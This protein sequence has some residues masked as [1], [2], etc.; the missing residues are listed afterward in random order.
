MVTKLLQLSL[1]CTVPH[2]YFPRF[3]EER[4][5]Q[6]AVILDVGKGNGIL[7]IELIFH[8]NRSFCSLCRT[9]R[10]V[11]QTED[12]SNVEVKEVDFMSC[13]GELSGFDLC[14][15][16]G[17]FDTIS[18]NQENTEGK[19]CYVQALR[20]EQLLQMLSQGERTIGNTPGM[21]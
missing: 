2:L 4:M 3:G 21:L 18:L 19:A 15:D 17:A 1:F 7:L 10:N 8:R 9:S 20:W 5:D 11:L 12:L 6:V 14:I 16:K 13:S